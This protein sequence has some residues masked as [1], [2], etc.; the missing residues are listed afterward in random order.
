M[1]E[2]VNLCHSDKMADKIAG[3]IVDF[4]YK[5]KV[6]LKVAVETLISHGNCYT[7]I[8]TRQDLY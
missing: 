6:N 4:M 8:E 2:E 5:S 3:V 1:I 7:I